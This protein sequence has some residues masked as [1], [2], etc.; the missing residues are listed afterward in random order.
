MKFKNFMH[1]IVVLSAVVAALLVL[2]QVLWWACLT[3][4]GSLGYFWGFGFFF[5][6]LYATLKI[7][8]PKSGELDEKGCPL[9]ILSFLALCAFCTLIS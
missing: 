4:V 9:V 3:I 2:L 6:W 8:C 1:D 5:A 7:Q